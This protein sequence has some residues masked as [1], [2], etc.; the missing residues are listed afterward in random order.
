MKSNS[1]RRKFCAN[2]EHWHISHFARLN[3]SALKSSS[4]LNPNESSDASIEGNSHSED[5]ASNDAMIDDNQEMQVDLNA[6]RMASLRY[7]MDRGSTTSSTVRSGS[8]ALASEEKRVVNI[9]KN[10]PFVIPFE[11][12]VAI[13][14]KFVQEDKENVDPDAW[15]TPVSVRREYIFEDG[16]SKLNHFSK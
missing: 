9:L 15:N 16:F 2:P 4:L 13:F 10:I 14:R 12:R 7:V 5:Q 6:Q 3:F 11:T 8:S 1:S